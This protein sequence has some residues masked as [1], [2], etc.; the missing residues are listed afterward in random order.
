V[1]YWADGFDWRAAERALN[2]YPHYLAEVGGR[3]VHF[4]HLRGKVTAGAPAPLPLIMTHGWPSSF[5]EMLQAARRSGRCLRRGD[6]LAAGLP[7]LRAPAGAVHPQGRRRAMTRADDPGLRLPALR[8]LRRRH[9]R[10]SDPVAGHP[11]R[12]RTELLNGESLRRRRKRLQA[13]EHLRAANELFERLSA[14]PWAE[15]GR[16]GSPPRSGCRS[17]RPR[18]ARGSAR[19]PGSGAARAATRAAP[20]ACGLRPADSRGPGRRS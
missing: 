19:R 10:R 12:A 1:T 20:A 11:D 13:R 9:R 15:R 6:P 16:P 2:A 4:V 18:T 5:V 17:G 7:V 14:D 3:W 8:S